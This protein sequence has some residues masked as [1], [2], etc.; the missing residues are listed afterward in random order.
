[1]LS[2]FWA[3]AEN[4]GD[5]QYCA[6]RRMVASGWQQDALTLGPAAIVLAQG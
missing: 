4:S 5:G 2:L 6:Q 3:E 1:M